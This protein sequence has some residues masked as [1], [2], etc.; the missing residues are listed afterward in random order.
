MAKKKKDLDK[1]S[2][3]MIQCEKDGYGCHY[4]AWKAA[5]ER[6]VVV[7]KKDEI[8]E[9]W[10]VCKQCGKLFKPK[11]KRK[12]FYCEIACQREA[13]LEKDR[14]KRKEYHRSYMEKKRAAERESNEQ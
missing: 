11:T 4:G 7:K 2:L 9:G 14:E 3:D 6:P 5:Q 13:Q 8:P 12:Q 10:L 1:L